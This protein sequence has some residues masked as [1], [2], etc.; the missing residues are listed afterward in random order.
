MDVITRNYFCTLRNAAFGASEATEPMSAYKWQ[1][2]RQRAAQDDVLMFI[3]DTVP[4]HAINFE[5]HKQGR[6][7]RR[8]AK[9]EYHAIDTSLDTLDML[10]IMLYNIDHTLSG[11][12][13]LRAIIEMGRY[14]RRKG[15][16]VD[17]VKLESWL[18][19]LG[20]HRMA[21]LHASVLVSLFGFH[22]DELPFMNRTA[23]RAEQLG[24][25]DHRLTAAYLLHY[26]AATIH[27]ALRRVF[28][29]ITQIEE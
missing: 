7:F 26:P 27:S 13:S 17:F 8:I 4:R 9:T 29:S 20:V 10:N 24:S 5:D 19:Q 6:K 3:D 25:R 22:L 23:P 16:R 15:D 12:T 28:H 2:L 21:R 1:Q 11:N 14:L 18:R